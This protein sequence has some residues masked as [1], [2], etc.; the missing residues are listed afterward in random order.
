MILYT[1]VIEDKQNKS[2]QAQ[3]HT[4]S[5]SFF[6]GMFDNMKNMSILLTT[7]TELGQK[8]Q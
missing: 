3:H 4:V 8:I 6:L 5:I 2:K 1:Y 7:E